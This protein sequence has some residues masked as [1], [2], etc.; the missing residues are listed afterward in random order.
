MAGEKLKSKLSQPKVELEAWQNKGWILEG[1]KKLLKRMCAYF[2]QR[3]R[4]RGTC[5]TILN[6][7]VE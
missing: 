4:R 7:V 5:R 1:N 3:V 6:L 2:L